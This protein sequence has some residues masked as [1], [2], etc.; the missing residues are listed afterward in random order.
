MSLISIARPS[1]VI[2][3]ATKA[4]ADT[5][6]AKSLVSEGLTLPSSLF[7]VVSS[8]NINESRVC[9]QIVFICKIVTKEVKRNLLLGVK[10]K[11]TNSVRQ[12]FN[13]IFLG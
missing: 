11:L 10:K 8:S 12:R 6:T 1:P 3:A 4:E 7:L 2:N 13:N 5:A 9:S